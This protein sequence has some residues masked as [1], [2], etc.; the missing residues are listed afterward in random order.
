MI[1]ISN[2]KDRKYFNI[3]DNIYEFSKFLTTKERK[4]GR[5]NHSE[6]SDYD[7]T[8]THSFEEAIELMTYGDEETLEKVLKEQT[9]VKTSNMLGNKKNRQ[10]YENRVYGCVPNVPAFLIGNPINMIN[11]EMNRPSHKIVNIFLNMDCSG[12]VSK[13]RILETGVKFLSVIDILEQNGYRCNLYAGVSSQSC[14]NNYYMLVRVKTDREPLNKKK[15]CFTIANPSFLR[16]IF[17]RWCEVFDFSE[18]ITGSYGGP[19]STKHCIKDFNNNVKED[20][21][22]WNYQ[23]DDT[24]KCDIE[25]VLKRLKE[26]GISIE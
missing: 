1:E 10:N 14:S 12:C 20:F 13:D 22:I 23:D 9:K 26:K 3:F 17:F 4:T 11:M 6:T 18:D 15:I 7:F 24:I 5:S 21:I 16:R 25:T 8:G 2:K 19:I